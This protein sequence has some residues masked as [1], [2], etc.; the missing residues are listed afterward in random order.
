MALVPWRRQGSSLP[1]RPAADPFE[2]LHREMDRLF[3]EVSR[4]WLAPLG[5]QEVTFLPPIEVT[6]TDDAIRVTAELPGIEEKDFELNL[7][8]DVLTLRGEK[9]AESEEEKEGVHYREISYGRFERRVQLPAEVDADNAQAEFKNGRLVVT[10]P[11]VAK[12]SARKI[13]VRAS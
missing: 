1:T 13:E 6:E 8:G 11:K 2:A 5:A 4:G 3:E 12:S 10:L 9:R 7:E